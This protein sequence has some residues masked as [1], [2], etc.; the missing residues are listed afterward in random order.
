MFKWQIKQLFV[1]IVEKNS[2]LLKASRLSTKKKDSI[3]SLKD[4]L[5]VEEQESNKVTTEALEDNIHVTK[6]T[7]SL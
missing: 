4:V 2:Y 1:K 5:I 3:M 6:I 7:V